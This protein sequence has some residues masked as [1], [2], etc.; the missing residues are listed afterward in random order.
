[1]SDFH[2]TFATGVACEQGTLSPPGTWFRPNF[3][4]PAYSLIVETNFSDLHQIYDIDTEFDLYRITSGFHEASATGVA[5]Q[6]G[7]LTLPDTWYRPLFWDLFV[8]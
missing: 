5:C 1:M 3:W 6:Q 8:L 4:G 7:A 2:V